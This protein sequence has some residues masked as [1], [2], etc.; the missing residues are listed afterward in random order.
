MSEEQGVRAERVALLR[1]IIQRLHEG[2]APDEVRL[3][4]RTLVR[5]TEATE[6]ASMEQSLIDAGM[7]AQQVQKM[8]DLHSQVLREILTDDRAAAIPPGHPVDSFERENA[9]LMTRVGQMRQL[10]AELAALP[11]AA[12]P[13]EGVLGWRGLF[14]ELMDVEKHYQR[15]EHLVFSCLERHGISGPTQVMWGKDDEV[16]QALRG[17]GEELAGPARTAREW[18]EVGERLAAPA[19]AAIEEMVF[20][21]EKILFPM[22]LRTLAETEWAEIWAQSIEYGWC[23]VEP[24]EGYR[25][26][27]G[28]TPPGEPRTGAIRLPSGV[29]SPE[30]LNGIFRALPVDVTFVDAEDR[31]RF[32]SPGPKRVFAR[33]AA[34]LGRKVQHCHPPQS[35]GSVERILADFREGRQDVAEFWIQLRGQFV[36]I[37]YF[38]V[39][40][41]AGAYLGTLEVTQDVTGIR[42]LQ[43]ERRLL[44]YEPQGS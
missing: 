32:F 24:R 18:R 22:C 42:A 12:D 26:A 27:A 44:Q 9:A 19:L 2:A 17:L 13:G 10:I 37:R 23:L 41:E 30:Q 8:C 43:G 14:N 6:I 16:R 28:A 3:Q 7:P 29:F 5:E 20:K 31:V 15:K 40:S 11:D 33:S 39:R 4:L 38:A 21:E 36:H 1:T 34:I 35:V 25:P